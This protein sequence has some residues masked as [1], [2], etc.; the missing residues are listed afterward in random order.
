MCK[1]TNELLSFEKGKA[2]GFQKY[3]FNFL[4]F[5]SIEKIYATSKLSFDVRRGQFLI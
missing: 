1:L 4:F 3:I 5:I 2:Y